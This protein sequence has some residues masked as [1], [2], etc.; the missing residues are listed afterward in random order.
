MRKLV[1]NSFEHLLE[2]LVWDEIVVSCLPHFEVP[3]ESTKIS[4]VVRSRVV[5]RRV[6]TVFVCVFLFVV[7]CV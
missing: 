6:E 7:E 5:S 1:G 3:R 2:H 4:E